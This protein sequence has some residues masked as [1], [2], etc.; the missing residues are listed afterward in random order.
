MKSLCVAAALMLASLFATAADKEPVS[1]SHNDW[2]IACD[3]TR[4]CRAAGYQA[5]NGDS[6]PVS[7]LITRAA[8]PGT[9]VEMELQVS[10]DEPMNGPA[11]LV[12]GQATTAVVLK[13]S[14][15][16]LNKDQIASILPELL[17]GS[18]AAV[19][20][21]NGKKWPLS[22]AGLNA[23]LLKM[24]EAQGRIGTPAALVRRGSKPESTV[25]PAVPMPVV[26]VIRPPK[27]RAGDQALV[28]RMLPVLDLSQAKDNCGIQGGVD[29]KTISI[30]R[31]TDTRVL[32]SFACSMGAYNYTDLLWI[33][34]DMPPYAPVAIEA[35]GAF[36]PKDAG[37]TMSM[38]GRGLGDCWSHESW[39]FDGKSFVHTGS[40]GDGMCR[41]FPGGAWN[42]PQ[43][44]S[45]I[46]IAP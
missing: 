18:E 1:F 10:D 3:N 28:A 2:E 19:F 26:N 40:S 24:D 42:L 35:N 33:A 30:F 34:N 12:V 11:R 20:S 44:V 36:E 6:E 23:V 39:H 27:A 45:R 7:L 38:K 9:Q 41:G 25:L 22:L 8:G 46:E 43:L 32:L 17:K 31:L 21:K 14:S 15:A 5:D 29:A 16:P 13:A 37:V 4:T